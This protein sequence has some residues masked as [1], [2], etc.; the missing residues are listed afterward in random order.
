MSKEMSK[1]QKEK[2][3]KEK[4]VLKLMSALEDAGFPIER[5]NDFGTLA[6]MVTEGDLADRF[7]TIKIVL[8]KEYDQEKGS[9]FDIVDAIVAY[10][11]RVEKELAKRTKE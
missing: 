11:D 2:I 4:E 7:I 5:V 3:A 10:N 9:G 6:Y 8:T 1:T